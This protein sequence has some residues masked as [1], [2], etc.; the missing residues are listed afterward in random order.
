M[1]V[2]TI[3][4][5]DV[6]NYGASLQAYALM[7]FIKGCGHDVKIIDYLPEYKPPCHSLGTFYNSGHA[8]TVGRYAPWLKP[9]MAFWQNR[10]ELRFQGRRR[11]FERFKAERLATTARTYQNN[12]ELEQGLAADSDMKADLYIAGS[13]Q[14]WNPYYG[15]GL[16]PA[17][18]CAFVNN[19]PR[20]ISYAAS[21]GKS[22]ITDGERQFIKPR[23]ANFRALSV[24]EKTGV[25]IARSMG[26]DAVQV[27][28]PVFLLS[29]ETWN[30][31][32]V[33]PE[34][35]DY[36]L[37]YDFLHND[38]NI[39][40]LARHFAQTE[41]LRIVA[42]ND[43]GSLSYADRNVS[44]AGPAEF[45]GY[46]RRA[47]HVLASS[48]H[49][50]AFS[51]IFERDFYIFPMKGHGNSSRMT[52]FLN[53]IGL[54]N[55]FITEITAVEGKRID[56]SRVNMLLEKQVDASRLWLKRQMENTNNTLTWK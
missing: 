41:G 19:P 4:C 16:D 33:D 54:T 38:P 3:T 43:K 37:V 15:N 48:F 2:R 47:K 18:Y 26:Y 28:D 45:L 35:E 52:D 25:E 53:S 39:E 51:T 46:I 56:F 13:D 50:A 32:S 49:A 6:G 23:L 40:A 20:C 44:N 9:L 55:R 5:H 27:V 24:R 17:Y 34:T 14:I 30:N 10:K 12:G 1:K 42:V 31:I 8:A 21:F 22:D 29:R 7:S 11:A 36:V